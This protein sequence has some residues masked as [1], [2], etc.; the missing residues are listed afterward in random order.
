M[1]L[2]PPVCTDCKVYARLELESMVTDG[3]KG[4]G[5]YCPMCGT[6]EIGNLWEQK[7]Q[8]IYD[9]NEKFVQFVK[10]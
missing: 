4:R 7:D 2:G 3:T 10:G 8:K 1:G 5:W 6:Q 9:V